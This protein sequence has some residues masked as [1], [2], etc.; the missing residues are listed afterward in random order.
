[1]RRWRHPSPKTESKIMDDDALMKARDVA[2][3]FAIAV[4]TLNR[5]VRTDPSFPRPIRLR[6]QNRFFRVQDILAWQQ[7]RQLES[8]RTVPP[9]HER[10]V[11]AGSAG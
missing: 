11:A 10:H 3:H 8:P 7:A 4:V 5:W 2:R 9:V 1:M 6:G